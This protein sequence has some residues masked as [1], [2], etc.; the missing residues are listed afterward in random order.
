MNERYIDWIW[1]I[2]GT[3]PLAPGQSGA[4]ALERLD[5]LF[6]QPGTTHDRD[7]TRLVFTKKDQ[8]AQDKMAVFDRGEIEVV[9][10]EQGPVL[11]YRLF[12]RAL[13]LCFLAPLLFLGLAQLTVAL[14][15]FD[16]PPTAAEKQKEDA[17]AR[18][19]AER[20]MNPIDKA[21][22]MPAPEKPDAN[23]D[24]AKDKDKPKGKGRSPTPAY[25]F[26]GFFAALYVIGRILEAWLIR[27]LFGKAVLGEDQQL[28]PGGSPF[29]PHDRQAPLLG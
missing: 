10:G 25:V 8:A 20:P 16:T 3:L 28:A 13:L 11:R 29:A 4:Q 12:S 6:N 26:A 22:G 15:K 24:K 5:P 19:M 23:K 9:P 27:R 14:G 21:L 18:A 1:H 7:G 2:S 17:K